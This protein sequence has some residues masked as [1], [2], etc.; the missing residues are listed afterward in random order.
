MAKI[1]RDNGTTFF[2]VKKADLAKENTAYGVVLNHQVM[3]TYVQK[4]KIKIYKKV[5]KYIEELL[6]EGVTLDQ[7]EIDLLLTLEE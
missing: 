1:D 6:T 4:S 7:E 3:D 2:V 5:D